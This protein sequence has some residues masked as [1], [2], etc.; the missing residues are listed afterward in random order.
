[1]FFN[2]S[3]TLQEHD[4]TLKN[5]VLVTVENFK[6]ETQTMFPY[7]WKYE[8][9]KNCNQTGVWQEHRLYSQMEFHM[10]PSVVFY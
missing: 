9:Q 10:G 1:M 3:V 4:F 8:K 5:A 7:T 6:C 2:F